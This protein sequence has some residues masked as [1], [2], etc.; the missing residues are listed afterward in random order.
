MK[1]LDCFEVISRAGKLYFGILA[2][3]VVGF[4]AFQRSKTPKLRSFEKDLRCID[5]PDVCFVK[6]L[7]STFLSIRHGFSSSFVDFHE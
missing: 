5:L 7:G 3:H 4:W 1:Y 2:V 6:V